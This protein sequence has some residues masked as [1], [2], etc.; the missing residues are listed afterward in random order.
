MRS[1]RAR[2][3]VV[4]AA[5]AAITAVLAVLAVPP[6]EA[7]SG[8]LVL[9]EGSGEY[10]WYDDPDLGC[11]PGPGPASPRRDRVD[12]YTDSDVLVYPAP[13]CRGAPSDRVA[14]HEFRH[15]DH[16]GSVWVLH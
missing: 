5:V 12:N 13:N 6:A 11:Y 15:V 7:A 14:P 4:T 9:A 16:L 1:A 2:S 8:R 3:P 10:V